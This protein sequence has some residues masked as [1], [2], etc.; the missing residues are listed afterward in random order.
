MTDRPLDHEPG[1]DARLAAHL[2]GLLEPAE[3]AALEER[4][5]GDPALRARL[6]ALRGLLGGELEAPDALPPVPLPAGLARRLGARLAEEGLL[7][8]VDD[9]QRLAAHLEGALEP[10]AEADLLGRLA[11][12]PALRARREALRELA[13]ESLV[14]R[15]LTPLVPPAG[16]FELTLARLEEEALLAPEPAAAAPPRLLPGTLARLEAEGLLAS[17]P[18]AALPVRAG[19]LVR[20]G[21]SPWLLAA[22][23]LLG[24]VGAFQLGSLYQRLPALERLRERDAAIDA[25]QASLQ[26][27]REEGAARL[28]ELSVA[29]E[30]ARGAEEQ[31]RAV[32]TEAGLL[33][34][35]REDLQVALGREQAQRL[36]LEV[37]AGQVETLRRERDALAARLAAAPPPAAPDP[38]LRELEALLA[39]RDDELNEAR[40]EL[41]GAQEALQQ[42]RL[43]AEPR[44]GEPASMLVSDARRI[45]RWDAARREWRPVEGATELQPGAIVRGAG[46]RGAIVLQDRELELRGGTYVVTGARRLDPLPEATGR[47]AP[48]RAAPGSLHEEVPQLIARLGSG[49][50]GERAEAQRRLTALWHR[51]PDPGPGVVARIAQGGLREDTPGPPVTPQAWEGWWGR[52]AEQAAE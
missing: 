6:A 46:S 35:G 28:I 21:R 39:S 31:L 25:L 29:R 2:E 17:A 40:L 44:S 15:W 1:D 11:A 32:R 7:A 30:Q 9:D 33:A 48:V 50:A 27:Q 13:P 49:S 16:L 36:A 42:A 3:A 23:L 19:L 47:A 26:R 5:T 24:C 4:L 8:P 12:E 14:A 45:D 41:A 34:R 22:A 43:H 52:V 38:R 20:V 10:A 51:F 18:R 37:E